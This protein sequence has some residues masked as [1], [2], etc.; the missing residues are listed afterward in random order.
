MRVVAPRIVVLLA[1]LPT[2][3]A[4][5]TAPGNV[6]AR[7]SGHAT[8]GIGY[9]DAAVFD[10]HVLEDLRTV[11]RAF[12]DDGP[13]FDFSNSPGV[14]HFLL[15]EDPATTYFHVS[16]AI[17]P[18]AQ[19]DLIHQLDRRKPPVIVY[20]SA[21]FGLS[22]WDG[23]SNEVRHY[24]VSD[25]ILSH[26][27]P[28]LRTHGVLVL[29]RSD[30]AG[31][32]PTLPPLHEPPQSGG[33]DNASC[34]WGL[35]AAYLTSQPTGKRLTMPLETARPMRRI[36]IQGW[37]YD[38][39]THGPADHVL[40]SVGGQLVGE[41]PLTGRTAA[42]RDTPGAAGSGFSGD[43]L[44]TRTGKVEVIAASS[45][46]RTTLTSGGDGGGSAEGRAEAGPVGTL[47]HVRIA[48][49]MVARVAVPPGTRLSDYDLLTFD[50]GGTTIGRARLT[51]TDEGEVT[52]GARH[53]ISARS[54][55]GARSL[56]VRVGS[57]AATVEQQL[58][59]ATL[60]ACGGNKQR[61]AD[62]LGVSLKTLYNRLAAY[63]E[64]ETA[65]R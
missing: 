4:A 6:V 35:A 59:L 55:A 53:A 28:V 7:V 46:R 15:G 39:S 51:V 40:V 2:I 34:D 20:D 52:G 3:A 63:R 33:V 42:R 14:V 29:V 60:A 50:G 27:T 62:V 44:T 65:D 10:D 1:V 58:I 30:L 61:A 22:T 17:P 54:L 56:S 32:L 23:V 21:E 48:S 24:L 25:F 5:W 36:A 38:P 64:T 43:V 45:S 8:P 31:S 19:R 12:D 18:V 37:A 47:Q 57:T 26:W 13:V 49:A 9:T 41:L 11:L 16:M